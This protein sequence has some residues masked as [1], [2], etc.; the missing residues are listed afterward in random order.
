MTETDIHPD[1]YAPAIDALTSHPWISRVDVTTD[2]DGDAVRITV[3]GDALTTSRQDGS[4]HVGPLVAEH[5]SHWTEVYDWTYGSAPVDGAELAGWRATDTGRPLPAEH[6]TEWVDRTVELILS[7]APTFVLELGCGTGLLMRKLA[8]H[9]RRYVGTDVAADVVQRL[10]AS[11][12]PGTAFVT[13]AAHELKGHDVRRAV[14]QAGGRPDCILLNS[15][16]QC[17]PDVGYLT[18]VLLDAFD[19]V[20]PGG[21]VIV[22]DIRHSGLLLEFARWSESAKSS[23]VDAA[24]LV[25][26]AIRRAASDSEMLLDPATLATIAGA[27]DRDVTL[28]TY[29]KTLTMDSELD[30]YRFDAV[31]RVDRE[32][33]ATTMPTTVTWPGLD[34][35]TRGLEQLAT[36]LGATPTVIT[37]IPRSIGGGVLRGAVADLDAAV[38]IDP[39]DPTR[40]RLASPPHAGAVTFADLHTPGR[41]HE[42]LG[43]FARTRVLQVARKLLRTAGI[44]VPSALS[45]ELP[46]GRGLDVVSSTHLSDDVDRAGR[47]AVSTTTEPITDE[48]L[49]RV[50][51]A[52]ETLDH[53]ALQALSNFLVEQGGVVPGSESSLKL[54]VERLRVAPRHLWIV[55]RWIAVLCLEERAHMVDD[56]RFVLALGDRAIPESRELARACRALGYP[57]AMAEFYSTAVVSLGALLADEI[58]AQALMFPDGDMSTSLGKDENNV[59][60][61]YL[62]SAAAHALTLA[63][64]TRPAPLRVLELGGGAGGGTRAALAALAGRDIDYQFTDISRFFTSAADDRFGSHPGFRTAVVDIDRPLTDQGLPAAGFDVVMA[65]NVLHC[66]RDA[67]FSTT[68]IADVL[69]PGGVAVVVEAVHEHFLVLLTMQFLLSPREPGPHPGS[70]DRRAGSGS[71]FLTASDIRCDLSSAGLRTIVELPGDRTPLAAPSQRLFVAQAL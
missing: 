8:P 49:A 26:S 39:D 30:R 31:L 2:A 21:S 20:A 16:T 24:A 59:S 55:R 22:G 12:I 44:D 29:A 51:G 35:D 33:D 4:A 37:D 6:M 15:V 69:A 42:P 67:S 23:D 66:A 36:L 10:A 28:E 60:N 48:A 63:A 17:F 53:Y 52:V 40:L 61:R 46:T 56:D 11:N 25:E 43:A 9:V 32:T 1:R 54:L 7:T 70:A 57:T 68:G 64:D 65:A 14:E 19:A 62:H 3:A 45:V 5:L 47:R 50:P 41:P 71:A 13:A 58:S 27:A 34:V 38:L 18:A